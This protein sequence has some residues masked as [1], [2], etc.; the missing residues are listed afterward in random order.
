MGLNFINMLQCFR[1]WWIFP[2]LV[3]WIPWFSR[4]PLFV[5]MYVC[6]YLFIVSLS[7][8]K[9]AA[10][11][12]YGSSQTRGQIRAAAAGHSHNHSNTWSES[13]LPPTPQL[14]ETLDP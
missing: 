7:L 13:R 14:T 4:K 5:C 12:A 11:M 2:E 1:F 8:F 10:P 3:L 9:R 6:V